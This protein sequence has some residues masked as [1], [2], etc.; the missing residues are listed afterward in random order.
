[1]KTRGRPPEIAVRLTDAQRAELR[2]FA[3][4][5][6]GYISERAHFVLF[7]DQGVSAPEIAQ[8]FGCSAPTVYTWLRRYE[9]QGIRGLRDRPRTGRPP[10]EALLPFIVAAQVCMSPLCYGYRLGCWTVELVCQ[11]LTRFGVTASVPQVR[12][13]LG[14]ANFTWGRAKLVLP[15]RRDPKAAEKLKRL[16][17]ALTDPN[18]VVL[19]TDE[20]DAHLMPVVRGT[21]H[22]IGRQPEVVTPGQ[23]QKRGVFGAVDLRSGAFH[24]MLSAKKRSVEFVGFLGNLVAA[25]PEKVL[26]VMVDN[27]SIHTSKLTLKWVAEHPQVHLVYLPTYAGHEYNP[28]EKVWWYMKDKVSGCLGYRTLAELDEAIHRHFRSRT[29]TDHLRLINSKVTRR[30]QGSPEPIS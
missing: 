2:G 4:S 7:S 12:R 8:R 30:A 6:P 17:E 5:E 27:A 14:R 25:Y 13:A 20:C 10:K 26:Y 23:N 21:W 28:I 29:G 22:A 16:D 9:R 18:G 19:S 3:R 11:H 1:M 15:H 24:Y